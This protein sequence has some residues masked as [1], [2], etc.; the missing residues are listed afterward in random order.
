V[1]DLPPRGAVVR[2]APGGVFTGP[3]ICTTIMGAG[4]DPHRS[5]H[6]FIGLDEGEDMMRGS[7]MNE[8][9]K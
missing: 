8:M 6:A 4:L 7:S 1:R 5:A 2:V 9:K 3:K